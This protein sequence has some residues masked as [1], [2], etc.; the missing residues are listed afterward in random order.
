[1]GHKDVGHQQ[2]VPFPGDGCMQGSQIGVRHH[3]DFFQEKAPD[4]K[5]QQFQTGKYGGQFAG[6]QNSIMFSLKNSTVGGP[7]SLVWRRI[8]LED[9]VSI[10]IH[11]LGGALEK[12]EMQMLRFTLATGRSDKMRLLQ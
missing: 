5:V 3:Q 2:P 12:G 9:I 11:P 7:C 4:G 1:V 8:L 6:I 10:R